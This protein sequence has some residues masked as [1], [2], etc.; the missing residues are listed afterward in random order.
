[1]Y[2]RFEDMSEEEKKNCYDS[3][4]GNVIYEFGDNAKYMNYEEWCK[5]SA[6]FGWAI[7]M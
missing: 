7:I 4:V 6:E 1:M 5:E 3:Y 2:I